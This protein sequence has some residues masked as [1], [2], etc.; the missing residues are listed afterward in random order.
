MK[1]V[2]YTS[3]TAFTKQNKYGK[4]HDIRLFLFF[5]E[6]TFDWDE[7]KL[8]YEEGLQRYP[9]SDWKWQRI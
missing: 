1:T 2:R 4:P 9:K 7:D 6:P 3:Y 5:P 8:T